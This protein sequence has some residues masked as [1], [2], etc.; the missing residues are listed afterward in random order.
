MIYWLAQAAKEL[1]EAADRKHVHIAA[2]MSKD[3]S[4]VYR[5]EAAAGWPRDTDVFIAAYADDLDITPLQIWERAL[6]LW[7]EHGEQANVAELMERQ[8][9]KRAK[10]VRPGEA[11]VPPPLHPEVLTPSKTAE[12]PKTRAPA[13][14]QNQARG[15][16]R[17]T[18]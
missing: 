14:R 1:R 10:K 18:A 15:S 16:K 17:R 7:K 3:Q 5:F 8:K 6:K 11:A 2:S 13:R 12:S 9:E 4:T